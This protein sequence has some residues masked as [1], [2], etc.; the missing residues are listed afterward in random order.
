MSHLCFAC[1]R[2]LPPYSYSRGSTRRSSRPKRRP[3]LPSAAIRPAPSWCRTNQRRLYYVVADGRAIGYPVGVGRAGQQWTG[4][5]MITGKYIKPGVVAARG[6]QARNPR[7]PNVIPGGS[8]RNPMGAA[9][10]TLSGGEYAIHGTNAPGSIGGF[11]SHGCI[12]MHNQPRPRS[13]CP[14]QRRHAGGRHPLT[15]P[16]TPK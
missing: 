15:R 6:H 1:W 10:L 12:R 16:I 9:A 7:L 14:R 5:A 11:V 4:T 13:L 3:P 8:P 2:P